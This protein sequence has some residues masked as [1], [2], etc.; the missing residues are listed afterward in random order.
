VFRAF[1]LVLVWSLFYLL[2]AVE[3]PS[4]IALVVAAAFSLLPQS[5]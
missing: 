1:G 2:R 4:R 3:V 5:L